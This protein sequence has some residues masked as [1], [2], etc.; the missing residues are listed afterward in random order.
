MPTI[1]PHLL[2]CGRRG[3]L[4]ATLAWSRPSASQ[5]V[6]LTGRL[7]LAGVLAGPL[8]ASLWHCAL[9]SSACQ[10]HR[11]ELAAG[12]DLFLLQELQ[13]CALPGTAVTL[14]TCD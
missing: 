10:D 8:V 11:T 6:H 12:R 13:A 3:G 2:P 4:E 1:C 7:G 5:C 14:V 9:H